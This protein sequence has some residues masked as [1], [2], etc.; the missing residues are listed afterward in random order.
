MVFFMSTEFTK[1]MKSHFE[2]WEM[3]RS[4]KQVWV[5]CPSK[6]IGGTEKHW[7]RARIVNIVKSDAL[8]KPIKHGGRLE[9]VPLSMLKMWKSMNAKQ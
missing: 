1:D 2:I 9:R 5:R 7:A 3:L 6:M 8:I 4:G